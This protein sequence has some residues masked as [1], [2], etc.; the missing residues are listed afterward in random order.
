M[1]FSLPNLEVLLQG[2]GLPIQ[3]NLQ[4]AEIILKLGGGT[5]EYPDHQ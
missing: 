4:A 5:E 2:T 3:R 1:S